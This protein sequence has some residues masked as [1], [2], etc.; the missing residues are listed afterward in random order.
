MNHLNSCATH[1]RNK[2]KAARIDFCW[3]SPNEQIWGGAD[4]TMR[5][6][7]L[8][9]SPNGSLKVEW[10][11]PLS[12]AGYWSTG[13]SISWKFNV[14]ATDLYE[15]TLCRSSNKTTSNIVAVWIDGV[16]AA[17]VPVDSSGGWS[18][19]VNDSLGK[20][21]LAA[22]DHTLAISQ[23][24]N[25]NVK[26]FLN[27]RSVSLRRSS[28]H[29][30]PI[31][32]NDIDLNAANFASIQPNNTSIRIDWL[33]NP[34]NFAYWKPGGEVIWDTHLDLS[35]DQPAIYNVSV[36]YATPKNETTLLVS[37]DG[38]ECCNCSLTGTGGLGQYM[39]YNNTTSI[40]EI[41][42]NISVTWRLGAGAEG[43]VGNLRSVHFVRQS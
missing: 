19:Y 28:G 31:I 25:D 2:R 17:E 6:A 4:L 39:L 37:I 35:T 42:D 10:K 41:K 9:R 15:V 16:L 34:L 13:D 30:S 22:G 1:E 7:V 24:E 8:L 33:A 23:A 32:G 21:N 43:E 36:E 5:N 40:Q 11:C 3:E 14:N 18:Q 12:N 26:D 29:S 38:I 20:Y 27:V